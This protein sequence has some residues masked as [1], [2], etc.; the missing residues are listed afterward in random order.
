MRLL[1]LGEFSRTGSQSLL[2]GR[3][4]LGCVVALQCTYA[5]R[6]VERFT[7]TQ[8]SELLVTTHNVSLLT[9][10]R[11]PRPQNDF[12]ITTRPRRLTENRTW[13]L[14]LTSRAPQYHQTKPAHV[15]SNLGPSAYQPSASVPPGQ[16]GSRR[17][18]PGSFRL[19]TERL[20]TTRPSRLTESRTCVLPLTSRA[21]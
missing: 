16:A 18:E 17:V 9:H 3:G 10:P 20:S 7:V 13:V 1:T 19:P 2:R 4:L 6:Y 21:P 8:C 14:P 15:E 5:E 11:R 12:R